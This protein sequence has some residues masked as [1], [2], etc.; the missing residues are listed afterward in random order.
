MCVCFVLSKSYGGVFCLRG[1]FVSQACDCFPE[2]VCVCCV[3]PVLFEMLSPYLCFVFL[4]ELVYLC[5]EDWDLW[6]C[7]VVL[8]DDVSLVY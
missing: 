6:I 4:Y 8:S 7:V 5:V 2:G 3:V 1:F